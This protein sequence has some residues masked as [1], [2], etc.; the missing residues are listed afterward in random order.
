LTRAKPTA[1]SASSTGNE[2]HFAFYFFNLAPE[3]AA[4][5][6]TLSYL[7]SKEFKRSPSESWTVQLRH[8]GHCR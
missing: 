6:S 1:I 3:P 5:S 7:L 4:D 2:N 8:S